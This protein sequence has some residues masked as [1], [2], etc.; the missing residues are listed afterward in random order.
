MVLS[1]KIGGV[2][3]CTKCGVEKKLEEFHRRKASRDG[4][5]ASCKKCRREE[6]AAY[7]A[8]NAE[9]IRQ[10]SAAWYAENRERALERERKKRLENLEE[11]RARG[12]KY[13]RL[14][15]EGA[16]R[17]MD[18]WLAD[19]ANV[20][21]KRQ[22]DKEWRERN[23]ERKAE[24]DRRWQQNNPERKL[25]AQKRWRKNHPE[26]YRSRI[27]VD[28]A[29]RYGLPK[30]D[31]DTRD[32]VLILEGDP[33]CY[34]GGPMEHIDHITP[35]AKGGEGE[36]FNLTA[37]CGECNVRKSDRPALTFLLEGR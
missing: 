25:A 16:K 8:K 37:S 19:P 18:K 4:L 3:R 36:W 2:K 15:R 22:K 9:K 30:P 29:R 20:E 13:A 1:G 17:R 31:A 14:D 5:N 28:H 11:F 7:N 32:F 6:Q 27:H 21:R 26:A 10:R 33:C 12:R 23:R 34:C 24:A 35:L